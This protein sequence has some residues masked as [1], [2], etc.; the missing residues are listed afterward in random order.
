MGQ[1]RSH[2]INLA[3][4]PPTRQW[5]QSPVGQDVKSVITAFID[6]HKQFMT[7]DWDK[8]ESNDKAVGQT[9][10]YLSGTDSRYD[11]LMNPPEGMP[12]TRYRSIKD[13]M[14]SYLFEKISKE[15]PLARQVLNE[16]GS[17]GKEQT[18]SSTKQSVPLTNM[19]QDA[20][21]EKKISIDVKQ[22][23]PVIRKLNFP[24]QQQSTD[25][26][27]EKPFYTTK[28]KDAAKR[29]FSQMI[30]DYPEFFIPFV[31]K[32]EQAKRAK[33]EADRL[34]KESDED[35]AKCLKFDDQE[36]LYDIQGLEDK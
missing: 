11:H 36:P 32:R 8:V 7:Y 27:P 4:E 30:E 5:Y 2:H 12:D 20:S 6:N 24:D 29:Y 25:S 21:P 10:N 3:A 35:M 28:Q 23:P 17:F 19:N 31:A 33:V 13:H 22:Q 1:D 16:H 15:S 26:S 34:Q 18:N 14:M 9:I